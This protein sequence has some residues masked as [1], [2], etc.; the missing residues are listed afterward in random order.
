LTWHIESQVDSS[1]EWS[2]ST[3]WV[4]V[5]VS[6]AGAEVLAFSSFF[7]RGVEVAGSGFLGFRVIS[8][9]A[10]PPQAVGQHKFPVG[11]S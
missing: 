9:Q 8:T 6:L 4:V 11:Q 3:G 2:A 10:A 5:G 1:S 7:G